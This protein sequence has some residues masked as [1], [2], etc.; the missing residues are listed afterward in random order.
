MKTLAALLLALPLAALAQ[1]A[2][3]PPTP[4]RSTAMLAPA[5]EPAAEAA[6]APPPRAPYTRDSWYLGFG[7]GTGA[8]TS[9]G[10][11]SEAGSLTSMGAGALTNLV[12]SAR[13]G[14]T[15]TPK[16]LV[17]LDVVRLRSASSST[18]SAPGVPELD[19]FK[20][21]AV[22]EIT[23]IDAMATFFPWQR[24]LLLRGGLGYSTLYRNITRHP[25]TGLETYRSYGA[26]ATLGAGYAFWLGE[27]FNLSLVVDGSWQHY[28]S[29]PT[30]AYGSTIT[31]TGLLTVWAGVDWF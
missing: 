25:S 27:T 26:N 4:A 2:P 11:G 28:F 10:T 31:D 20:A 8:G 23:D 24:G 22:N 3:P 30:T 21:S 6:P 5:P 7:F 19:G 14:V 18:I 17:G 16:L 29:T 1:S 15:L 9:T 13:G 12:L